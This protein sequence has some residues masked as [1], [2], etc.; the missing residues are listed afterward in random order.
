MPMCLKKTLQC[1]FLFP[2]LTKYKAIRIIHWKYF[3]ANYLSNVEI[4][5]K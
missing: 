2:S 5:L 1:F 3:L 4:Q